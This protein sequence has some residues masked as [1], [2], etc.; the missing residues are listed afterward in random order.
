MRGV[1]FSAV[2]YSA[3]AAR[4]LA[5]SLGLCT[6]TSGCG[7]Q[8]TANK[9]EPT[10]APPAVAAAPAGMFPAG[11]TP[12]LVAVPENRYAAGD[13]YAATPRVDPAVQPVGYAATP[14]PVPPYAGAIS[15]PEPNRPVNMSQVTSNIGGPGLP[16]NSSEQEFVPGIEDL[17]LFEQ[18]DI[19]S[20]GRTGQR[21]QGWIS[22]AE[23]LD[24]KV[25]QRPRTSPLP[26][27]P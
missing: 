16:Q 12:T 3:A 1:V 7:D 4:S 21:P 24:W 6:L 25:G 13:R 11:A 2:R 22:S 20:Y 15:T 19:S 23:M 27:S 5:L 10:A 17:Q 26:H 18:P 14:S 9:A 8:S